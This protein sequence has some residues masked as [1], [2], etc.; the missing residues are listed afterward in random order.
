MAV[1]Y[2]LYV[3]ALFAIAVGSAFFN[4]RKARGKGESD[5]LKTGK[6][7]DAS[8]IILGRI[9][10]ETV[11]YSPSNVE[12]HCAVFASSGAGKTT[13]ILQP[14]LVSF[15]KNESTAG[16]FAL[17]IS[18]DILRETISY[19]QAP[20]VFDPY[21][22]DKV[23]D[24][25]RDPQ[26]PWEGKISFT[27]VPYN[28]FAEI[29][30]LPEEEQDMALRQMAN[31]IMPELPNSD[32]ASR[33]FQTGGRRILTAALIAFY[34]GRFDFTEIMT[35]ICENGWAKLFAMIDATGNVSA[36]VL[37]N[38]FQGGNE[39][40]ISGCYDNVAAAIEFFTTDIC[41]T[42][43]RRPHEGEA[44]ITPASVEGHNVYICIPDSKIS[45]WA[46][47]M[48]LITAQALNYFAGRSERLRSKKILFLLDEFASLKLS[49]QQISEAAQK[50][51]KCGVRIVILLQ[52]LNSLYVL[53]GHDQT[54]ALLDNFVLQ[55]C[56][57]TNDPDCQE[58][59]AKKIGK[60]RKKGDVL[61]SLTRNKSRIASMP[62]EWIVDPSEYGSLQNSK[63]NIVI[64][65]GGYMRL[66]LYSFYR[67]GT[68]KW[69][70]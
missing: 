17:D 38:G 34:H 46:P 14:S 56:M 50:Y 69:Y 57:G 7:E 20:L 18:G 35:A 31:L 68:Y 9:H 26:S 52:S 55:V 44:C 4:I 43:I 48:G 15:L 53:Y 58:Y 21:Y 37:L 11:V 63:E 36:K 10:G 16:T 19:A 59:F 12:A 61:D 1:M 66:K 13:A 2:V 22:N 51:R 32:S 39:A 33:Y 67:R 65:P 6:A 41:K 25:K 54:K 45:V 47:V 60:E 70:E 5:L 3:L 30:K 42:S 28:V 24:V 49:V 62:M 64:F 23:D 29:D 40:N 8:G 27:P